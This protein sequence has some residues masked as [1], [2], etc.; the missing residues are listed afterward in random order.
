[1]RPDARTSIAVVMLL[2]VTGFAGLVS[3]GGSSDRPSSSSGPV[4]R[5][6]SRLK[7]ESRELK[8][9]FE[10]RAAQA[11]NDLEEARG[12]AE[13]LLAG[14]V[15][16]THAAVRRT[17]ELA[18]KAL[19]GGAEI[20]R[21]A[22]RNGDQIAEDWARLIQERMMRLERSLDALARADEEHADS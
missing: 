11:R 19:Y 21:Q 3:C 22:A 8:K 2:L 18:D 17:R 14:R 12:A 15:E 9:V 20:L 16:H 4:G 13:A 10:D 6:A 7:A 1:M 5:A